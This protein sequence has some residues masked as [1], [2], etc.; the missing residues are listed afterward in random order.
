MAELQLPRLPRLHLIEFHEQP[1]FPAFLRQYV[2]D[3]LA[4]LWA[5]RPP[6]GRSGADA[7]APVLRSTLE[8]AVGVG[9]QPRVVIDLCSGG[10]GPIA[11]LVPLLPTSLRVSVRLTDLFPNLDAF[12]YMASTNPQRIQFSSSPV[13]ATACTERGDFRTLF[14]SFH[15]FQPRVAEAMLRDAVTSGQGIAVFEMTQ[16]SVWVIVAIFLLLAPL[17]LLITPFMPRVTFGRLFF[18]Y[19]IP[20]VPATLVIDGVTSCLRTYTTGE[21]L[22]MAARADPGGA[23]NWRVQ[24][25]WPTPVIPLTCYIGVPKRP[26]AS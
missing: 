5:L 16:R 1:W 14:A 23:F 10:G 3:M 4:S 7:A 8:A 24:E 15:H 22:E 20:I 6:L 11:A 2:T 13:D 19:I 21:F 25:M 12:R 26:K 9:D 18:T 17:V